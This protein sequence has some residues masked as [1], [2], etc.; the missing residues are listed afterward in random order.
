LIKTLIE[1]KD[2]K[3][4]EKNISTKTPLIDW[5]WLLILIAVLLTTEWFIRKYNGLL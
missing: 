3:S 4:I 1:N 5:V 2:Y